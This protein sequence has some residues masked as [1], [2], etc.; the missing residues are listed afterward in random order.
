[1]GCSNE[2]NEKGKI[3]SAYPPLDFFEGKNETII[4]E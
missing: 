2:M 1:V 3:Y 4:I